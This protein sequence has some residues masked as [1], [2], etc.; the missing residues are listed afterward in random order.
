MSGIREVRVQEVEEEV[1]RPK[2][3]RRRARGALVGA[4]EGGGRV[5]AGRIA[6]WRDEFLVAAREGLKARPLPVDDRRLAEAQRKIGEL[7][8][9]LDILRALNEEMDRRPHRPRR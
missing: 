6:A 7:S 8:M 3:E 5:P 1:Q 9:E 2:R 4:P